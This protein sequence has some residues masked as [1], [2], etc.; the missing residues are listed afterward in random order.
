MD[1]VNNNSVWKVLEN[2]QEIEKIKKLIQREMLYSKKNISLKIGDSIKI[3]FAD[4][5]HI[6][7]TEDEKEYVFPD[8]FPGFK[9]KY[10]SSYYFKKIYYVMVN[11]MIVYD[12]HEEKKKVENRNKRNADKFLDEYFHKGIRK[13]FKKDFKACLSQL[14]ELEKKMFQSSMEELLT[15]L[16]KIE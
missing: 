7:F 8:K 14:P 16:V 5:K 3:L 4:T 9:I 13:Y 11:D 6:G 12:Y 1:P 15:S 2:K 10:T